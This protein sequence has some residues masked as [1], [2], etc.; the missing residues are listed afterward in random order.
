MGYDIIKVSYL[1]FYL[2]MLVYFSILNC[3]AII[4][5]HLVNTFLYSLSKISSFKKNKTELFY[6]ELRIF[7]KRKIFF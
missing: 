5:N 7:T 1:T 2:R 3:S 4:D 6:L